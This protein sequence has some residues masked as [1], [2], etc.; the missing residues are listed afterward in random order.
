MFLQLLEGLCAESSILQQTPL[1][2]MVEQLSGQILEWGTHCQLV[3]C[4]V[5]R[6]QVVEA[7]AEI[8]QS[9]G[10]ASLRCILGCVPQQGW[11]QPLWVQC[12]AAAHPGVHLQ[13]APLQS[14]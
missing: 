7:E 2:I 6:E 4:R 1:G 9:V 8:A 12:R 11:E 3:D 5:F 14:H 10:A 13:R